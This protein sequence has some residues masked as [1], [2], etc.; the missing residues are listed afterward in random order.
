MNV[1]FRMVFVIMVTAPIGKAATLREQCDH[2]VQV[3]E[4]WQTDG[5]PRQVKL[6]LGAIPEDRL[7]FEP[8]MEKWVYVDLRSSH[9][10]LAPVL[11]ADIS[12]LNDLNTMAEWLGGRFGF[13]VFDRSV[14]QFIAWDTRHLACIKT[15][16]KPT[17][18]FYMPEAGTGGA[19]VIHAFPTNVPAG[20][21]FYPGEDFAK[22]VQLLLARTAIRDREIWIPPILCGPELK[23]QLIAKVREQALEQRRPALKRELERVFPRVSRVQFSPRW[24]MRAEVPVEPLGF[25]VCGK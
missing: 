15:M 12:N 2:A 3:I 23:E 10:E 4:K 25:F 21:P 1:L 13:I 24:L 19:G 20:Q 7:G 14:S 16:L 17:G 8:P 18:R 11:Q 22:S 9:Q 6:M 5:D